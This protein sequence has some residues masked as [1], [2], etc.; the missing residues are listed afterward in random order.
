VKLSLSVISFR[1]GGGCEGG[2]RTRPV[3]I[4]AKDPVVDPEHVSCVV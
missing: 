1:G 4:G 3:Y 2:N